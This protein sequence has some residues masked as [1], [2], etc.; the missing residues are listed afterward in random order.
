MARRFL[1]LR[2]PG[3]DGNAPDGTPAIPLAVPPSLPDA[4]QLAPATVPMSSPGI[5]NASFHACIACV[6]VTLINTVNLPCSC[7]RTE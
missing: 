2:S 4:S 5:A 3:S 7:H 1:V 6:A